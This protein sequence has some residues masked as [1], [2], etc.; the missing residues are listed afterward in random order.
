[1]TTSTPFLP[2]N[3]RKHIRDP[4]GRHGESAGT[5]QLLSP[6]AVGT[7]GTLNE[8]L[9]VVVSQLQV[10]YLFL[11]SFEEHKCLITLPNP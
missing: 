6:A 3:V 7:T 11:H 9:G 8:I 4:T 5:R 10:D 1:M 2:P